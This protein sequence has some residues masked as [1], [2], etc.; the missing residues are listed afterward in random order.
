VSSLSGLSSRRPDPGSSQQPGGRQGE[1]EGWAVF[2]YLIAGMAF[3]GG[4][5]WLV[6]RWAHLAVLF[7][8]G[9]LVG[10]G[11]AILLIILRYGRA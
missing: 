4:I 7:P 1:Q 5:G 8:V 11:L 6:G 10:L 2:G 3:Y 9:M